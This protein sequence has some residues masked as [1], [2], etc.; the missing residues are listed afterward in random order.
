[1]DRKYSSCETTQ[2]GFFSSGGDGRVGP[3]EYHG[4]SSALAVGCDYLLNLSHAEVAARSRD[5]AEAIFRG[6]MRETHDLRDFS[7]M[8]GYS[9]M[10]ADGPDQPLRP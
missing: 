3:S 9:A 8:N 1:M 7:D 6:A 2:P 10:N 4:L 5:A